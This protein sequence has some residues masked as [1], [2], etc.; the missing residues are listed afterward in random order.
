MSQITKPLVVYL[1]DTRGVTVSRYGRGN[2]KIGAGVYTYSRLP[3]KPGYK[4]LGTS[5]ERTPSEQWNGTCPGA[6]A[7][8]LDICYARRPVKEMGAVAQMW[9]MN[10]IF[11]DVPDLPEDAVL[12]RLHVS[13]DFDTVDYIEKW[14]AQFTKRSDVTVWAYTKSWRVPELLPALERLRALPNVQ[15]FASMDRTMPDAPP[16]GWRRAWIDGD[17]RAG[18]PVDLAAHTEI[19][20]EVCSRDRGD[21][22]HLT[23]PLTCA[24][25]SIGAHTYKPA[26]R[27]LRTVDG[28]MTL[29][30]PEETKDR[31]N[32]EA[33]RYCF[34]GKRNDVTF[35]RH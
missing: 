32:C 7:E 12:V 10:S 16:A 31:A 25:Y 4:A 20:C 34:D 28:T 9:L 21:L 3:G 23:A 17:E 26:P 13:G 30:C 18:K 2:L 14:I 19:P 35:L 11:Q 5:E 15:L 8:C 1:P 29:V 27:N 33:C 6:S 22:K 24:S